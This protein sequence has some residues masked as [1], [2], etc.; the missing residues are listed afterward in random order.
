MCVPQEGDVDKQ[1]IQIKLTDF[2]F[3]CFYDPHY[4]LKT[5]LGTPL[6]MAPELV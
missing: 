6:Y 5:C 4:K 2:G 1:N 3:A